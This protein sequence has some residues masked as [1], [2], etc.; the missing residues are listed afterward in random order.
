MMDVWLAMVL[1]FLLMVVITRVV[2]SLLGASIVTWMVMLFALGIYEKPWYIMA[3]GLL[4]FGIGVYIAR[5][6]LKRKPGI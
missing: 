4:S 3:I 6:I 2:F 5:N 1:P